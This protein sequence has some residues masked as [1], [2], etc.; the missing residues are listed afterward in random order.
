MLAQEF[1]PAR[2]LGQASATNR[3][4]ITPE[5]STRPQQ[6][7]L[8]N[9]TIATSAETTGDMSAWWDG[10]TSV[11]E[12][13]VRSGPWALHY[14]LTTAWEYDSNFNLDAGNAAIGGG[15][16]GDTQIFSVSPYGVLTFGQPGHGLDFQLRYSPEFRWFSEENIDNVI[17]HNLSM[18]LGINGARSRMYANVGY[19]RN[20]NG[21]VEVGNLVSSDTYTIGLGGSYDVSPKTTIG[22][23]LNTN[24]SE[25]EAFNSFSNFALGLFVDYAVTPKT[26][27]GLGVGYDHLQQ[28]NNRN[29]NAYNVNLRFNWSATAKTGIAGS[30]GV[31]QREYDGGESMIAA[32]GRIGVYYN[33]TEKL[34]LQLS[35]YRNAS[36]SIGAADGMFYSTGLAFT[37]NLQLTSRVSASLSIGFENAQYESTG[38]DEFTGREDDYFFVRPAFT[39]FLSSHLSMNLFY[40]FT[41]NDTTAGNSF[42]RNQVGVSLTLAY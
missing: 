19:S 5:G 12:E 16:S 6:R 32:I 4:E 22:A 34:G 30:L 23:T 24:I 28:D 20:E 15:Q 36:P 14:G 7:E 13:S 42:S 33:P 9:D 31:E 39:F 2:Q 18:S 27:L 25:Y 29:A 21:N 38:G 8:T 37:S 1:T 40:Q 41:N 35:A 10:M 3:Y 17:N 26:R 11:A